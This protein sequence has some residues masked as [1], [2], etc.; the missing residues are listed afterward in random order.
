MFE[1]MTIGEQRTLLTLAAVIAL[2]LGVQN[3]QDNQ[4]AEPISV[5]KAETSAADSPRKETIP[6]STPNTVAPAANQTVAIQPLAS[7]PDIPAPPTTGK[8]NLNSAT[9]VELD[10]LPGIG[11]V[12]A[13]AIITYRS[14]IGGFRK[15]E[16]LLG[17]DG[18]GEK[19]LENVRNLVSVN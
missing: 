19:T 10:A 1:G 18:I 8:I 7:I 14:Q 2:G 15:V 6:V 3:Y 17:V 9:A 16:D 11:P 4:Q 12:R 5:K 13:Q